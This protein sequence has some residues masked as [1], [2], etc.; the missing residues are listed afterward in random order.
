MKARFIEGPHEQLAVEFIA[1]S[2]DERLLL[3]AFAKQMEPNNLLRV[4]GWKYGPVMEAYAMQTMR[5]YIVPTIDAVIMK[6][7]A[8]DNAADVPPPGD[9]DGQG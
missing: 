8:P 1:D 5:A 4:Q 2:D 6:V 3:K 9:T 7:R